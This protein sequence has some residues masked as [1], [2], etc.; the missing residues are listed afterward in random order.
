LVEAHT[1]PYQGA[2]AAALADL[3]GDEATLLGRATALYQGAQRAS[4]V[5]GPAIAGILIQFVGAASVLWIDGS[6][7][8]VCQRA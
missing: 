3:T 5:V 4:N 2:P 1:A 6:T 8:R 7:V